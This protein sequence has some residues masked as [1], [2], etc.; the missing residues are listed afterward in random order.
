M[1]YKVFMGRLSHGVVGAVRGASTIACS[2][3]RL[4][5]YSKPGCHL[6]EGLKVIS[7]SS[8]KAEVAT[9]EAQVATACHA[10][11][12]RHGNIVL[13]MAGTKNCPP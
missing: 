8:V 5:L 4:V 13:T 3:R 2:S 9:A 7:S 12:S 10:Q 6:C 11:S 1:S